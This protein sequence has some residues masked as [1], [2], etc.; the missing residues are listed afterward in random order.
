MA[1][2]K[3][4]VAN[5]LE[6][7]LHAMGRHTYMLDGD[8]IRHGLNKDLGFTD[9]DAAFFSEESGVDWNVIF[10]LLGMM[11]IVAVLRRTGLFEYVAIWSAKR[12]R[13]R[14]FRI[15]VTLSVV[16]AV[17]S[18]LLD[19][20]TTMLLMTPITLEIAL[21]LGMNP[22]SLLMPAL[23]A[24][25]VGGLA[26]LIGTVLVLVAAFSSLLAFRFGAPLLL[27][28]LGIGLIAGVDG[29]GI[30][31]DNANIAYFVGSLAL[32]IIL[33]DSGFGTPIQSFRQAAYPAITLATLG[34]VLTA[35]VF[36]V[37]ARY[38]LGFSW[39]EAFLLGAIVGSTDAAAVFFLLRAG[40]E[41]RRRLQRLLLHPAELVVR[42]RFA[43]ELHVHGTFVGGAV[44]GRDPEGSGGAEP[45]RKAMA[46]QFDRL[47][48]TYPASAYVGDSYYWQAFA[49]SRQGTR[50]DLRTASDL[51][52]EQARA[53]AQAATRADAEAL[54]V[55]VEAQ[56][57][58]RNPHAIFPTRIELVPSEIIRVH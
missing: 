30:D 28:F 51:L 15:L 18:A 52:R 7:R 44:F 43:V 47:R 24:S 26:T 16:T 58:N 57:A 10:L 29:L 32:A 9:A 50:N 22:L 21:A 27:V 37:A 2:G 1:A 36:G 40:D 46:E 20:V 54:L 56:L 48:S 11:L 25:N 33:F 42:D 31:F 23:L 34:V 6:K 35:A 53:Y 12:A 45:F 19:N 14:P 5:A 55:R 8:N 41:L 13:G 4:T 49:L 39:P 38:L 17:A 3:S